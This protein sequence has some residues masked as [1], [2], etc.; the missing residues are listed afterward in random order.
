MLIR[1]ISVFLENRNGQFAGIARLLGEN[2]INLRCFTVSESNDFGLARILVDNDDIDRTY[3]L[4]K[5]KSY[6]VSIN[7]VVYLESGNVPGSMVKAMDKLSEAGIAIE[8]MYAYA[9]S[10]S[11][12]SHIIIRAADNEELADQLISGI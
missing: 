12:I 6:G 3:N 8:Y 1:Q 7:N 9:E 2:N 5:S 10:E 11:S 4:L